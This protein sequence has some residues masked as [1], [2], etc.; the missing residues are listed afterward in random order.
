MNNQTPQKSLWKIGKEEY[1]KFVYLD[2][3]KK[4]NVISILFGIIFT[5]IIILPFAIFVERIVELYWYM[6]K[7]KIILLA[8]AWGL[9]L[10]CNGLSN[11][12][13][14]KIVKAYEK[15]MDE[16]QNIDEKAIFFYQTFNVG[17][18]LVTFAIMIFFYISSLI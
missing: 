15:D 17:F 10:I 3:K 1:K 13:T 8:C 7:T 4:T 18:A 6:A 16:V 5:A 2:L 14:V 9:L 12:I 11:Y